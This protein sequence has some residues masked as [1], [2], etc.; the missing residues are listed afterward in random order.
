MAGPTDSE[1]RDRL[2]LSPLE[3]ALF[4]QLGTPLKIQSFL[5]QMAYHHCTDEEYLCRS[6]LRVLR[7][8]DADGR[9][10]A[11]CLEGAL[12]GH[13]A[14]W[15]AGY[16][17]RLVNL[18]TVNDSDHIIAIFPYK[19]HL[20]AVA[21]SKTTTLTARDPIYRDLLELARSYA[22]TYFDADGQKSLRACSVPWDPFITGTAWAT[23]EEN[24]IHI[25]ELFDALPHFPLIPRGVRQ[26]DLFPA[27]RRL[28]QAVYHGVDPSWRKATRR[29]AD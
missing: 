9:H 16:Q 26:E 18:R 15:L 24:L 13:L 2:G 21:H 11:H 29:C 10:S 27:N 5:D 22:D 7:E 3:H 25:G 8:R 4:A 23:S 20:G 17:P 28:Q 19:G 6:P 12:F 14:L 1:L